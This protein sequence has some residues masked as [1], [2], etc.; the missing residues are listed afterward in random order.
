MNYLPTTNSALKQ[1]VGDFSTIVEAL[2]YAALGNTGTCFYDGQGKLYDAVSYRELRRRAIATGASLLE[3]GVH[4]LDAV[5]VVAE[6]SAEFLSVFYGCQYAGLLVCPLPFAVYPGGKSGYVKRLAI[7]VRAAQAKLL[8]L[9]DALRDLEPDLKKLTGLDVI[10]FSQLNAMESIREPQPLLSDEPAYIQF[11]SGSTAEP[12]GIII[13]QEAVTAN[14]RGILR[15]CI[16]INPGDRA[17]SWLPFYHD[18]GLVGFSIAPLFSQTSVDYLSSTAFARRPL[19]WLQLMSQNRSTI[20]YAP[21]FGYK[22]ASQ[23]LGSFEGEFDLCSL[24]IAG[25]GG[26]MIV[27][28]QLETFFEKTKN[29][30]FNWNSFTPSYGLAESTLLVT[31]RRGLSDE[32]LDREKIEEGLA[33]SR[34]NDPKQSRSF[35]V[36]GQPLYGHELKISGPDGS[37]LNE[38]QIGRILVRGPSIMSGYRNATLSDTVDEMGFLDTGD[39]GYMRDGELVVTGRLKDMITFNGRNIWPH[40]I[41]QTVLSLPDMSLTRTVTFSIEQ[42]SLETIIVLI[43]YRDKNRDNFGRLKSEIAKILSTEIG[44]IAHIVM[45]RPGSLPLTSSG[46]ISR[47]EARKAYL[48]DSFQMSD[49]SV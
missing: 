12:K 34:D 38:R 37:A 26:D 19:L 29:F 33:V 27:R 11:T 21:V 6:T 5:A 22:L 4:R 24:R 20:T 17:F 39:S 8:C 28:D 14:A 25:V 43:E 41:E 9:P 35:T 23:R 7:F 32:N 2:D 48:A 15:E 44:I 47:S 10:S 30:G 18:M 49:P 40:D 36:C 16:A 31:Y 42:A 45:V 13:S 3:T 46:K 1:R